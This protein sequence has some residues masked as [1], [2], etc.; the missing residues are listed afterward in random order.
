M[1]KD[2]IQAAGVAKILAPG[3]AAESDQVVAYPETGRQIN[4]AD[5][6]NG[7]RAGDVTS[8]CNKQQDRQYGHEAV[9]SIYNIASPSLSTDG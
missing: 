7:E 1:K 9:F 3:V 8:A 6:R 2:V 4:E 5:L